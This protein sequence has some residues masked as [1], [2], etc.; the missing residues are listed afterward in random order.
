MRF[1]TGEERGRLPC[2][3]LYR[4]ASGRRYHE[5]PAAVRARP[6]D[7]L[8]ESDYGMTALHVMCSLPDDDGGGGGSPVSD[9]LLLAVDSCLEVAP[10]LVE[11]PTVASWTPLHMACKARTTTAAAATRPHGAAGSNEEGL[12][13][14]LIRARPEAV[15]RELQRGLLSKT[16]FHLACE[17]N[18]SAAVLEAM[19]RVRPALATTPYVQISRHSPLEF[20]LTILWTAIQARGGGDDWSKMELLLRAATAVPLSLVTDYGRGSEFEVLRAACQINPCPRD[21]ISLLIQRHANRL[22]WSDDRS[23]LPLHYAVQSAVA[24]SQP[25]TEFLVEALLERYPDAASVPFSCP[26]TGPAR[27]CGSLVLPLHFLIYDRCM[28]WHRGGIKALVYAYPEAL[29]VRD[30]R[31]GLVPFLES[32]VHATKSRLHLSTTYELLRRAPEVIDNY[33]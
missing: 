27:P 30:P 14:R 28:T 17:A 9:A 31:N 10:H 20:P 13:L 15:G 5:I 8:W 32:A 26:N 23:C 2:P 22:S 19:L 1:P 7:V 6:Q 24:D 4:L 16:P 11:K 3:A 21:Y 33:Y 18:A 12:I 25:Y 29:R